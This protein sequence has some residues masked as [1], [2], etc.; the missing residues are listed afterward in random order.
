[1]EYNFSR[2]KKHTLKY[3]FKASNYILNQYYKTHWTINISYISVFI[4]FISYFL[5]SITAENFDDA[6]ISN[7]NA[8]FI[9][10]LIA[11]SCSIFGIW[12]RILF[13]M[14]ANIMY[15]RLGLSGVN[16]K[17]FHLS[18]IWS[19]VWHSIVSILVLIVIDFIAVLILVDNNQ[20]IGSNVIKTTLNI[21]FNYRLAVNFFYTMII[22]LILI[23]VQ[24]MINS[25]CWSNAIGM[26]IF[27]LVLV[28][29][30]LLFNVINIVPNIEDGQN[31]SLNWIG[32]SLDYPSA[33][34]NNGVIHL[35]IW[36]QVIYWILWVLA[37]AGGFSLGFYFA[38]R[39]FNWSR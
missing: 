38:Y 32:S 27:P 23:G 31:F 16:R 14:K 1:M 2:V 34:G 24:L 37:G 3:Q 6:L 29:L 8:V 12:N 7:S 28:V 21:V 25:M 33:N 36:L 22:M 5:Q 26:G 30:I 17:A 13:E 10:M 15:K 11:V 4:I 19:S 9:S 20:A 39:K 35:A 18:L